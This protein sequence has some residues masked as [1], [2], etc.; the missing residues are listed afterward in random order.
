[1]TRGRIKW[2][3]QLIG[4]GFI[5]TEDGEDVF[6]RLGMGAEEELKLLQRGQEVYFD[7][8]KKKNGLSPMAIN[9]EICGCQM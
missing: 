6:F 9:V 4:G 3:S 7:I 8:R 2:C 1:M 5:R